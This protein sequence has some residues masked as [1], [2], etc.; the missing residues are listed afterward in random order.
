MLNPELTKKYISLNKLIDY[1]VDT[2]KEEKVPSFNSTLIDDSNC[3]ENGTFI[4]NGVLTSKLDNDLKFELPI[5]YPKYLTATCSI[6]S[7]KKND[8]VNITCKT[9]GEID[10]EN[11]MISQNTILDNNKKELLII[12]KIEA[13]KKSKCNNAKTQIIN[14]KLKNQIKISFRQ[15]NQFYPMKKKTN[16]HFIG[17]SDQLLPSEKTLKILVAI[18]F[19]GEK[20]EKEANC[21]L[22]TFSRLNALNPNYGQANFICE[23]EHNE[24]DKADDLEIISSDKILGLNDDLEDSQKSPYKT[25]KMIKETLN[26]PSLGQVLNFS[27]TTDFYDIPPTFEISS[28]NF[29]KCKDKGKIKVNG[30][31]NQKIE[32][33]FDFTIPLSYPSSSIKCTAPNIDANRNVNI[34]CKIQKDFYNAEQIIIEPRIIKKKHKEVIF[35][36][37]Y[38]YNKEKQTCKNYNTIQKTIEAAKTKNNYSF[39]QANNFMPIP[40]GLFFRILIY[41]LQN[42]FPPTIPVT[43]SIRRRIS[44]LRNLEDIQEEDEISCLP[45]GNNI[46]PE[47]KGYNCNSTIK[48]K[49]ASDFEDF[50]FESDIV[51]G[52]YEENSNPILTDNNIKSGVVPEITKD[53]KIGSFDNPEIVKDKNC[54]VSGIFD[55]SGNLNNKDLAKLKPF[56]IHYSNPPDSYSV[57]NFTSYKLMECNNAEAFEDEYIVINKQT[58]ANGMLYIPAVTSEE[59][60]SCAISSS[61]SLS[62]EIP[63]GNDTEIENRYFSKKVSSGGLN[64]G[65]IAAIVIIS[66]AIL[67]GIGVLIALI[68]NGILFSD[69]P[70]ISNSNIP[71]ISSSSANII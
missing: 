69:K 60:F 63:V 15:V 32:Q 6:K 26:E 8:N 5:A 29:D 41:S 61:S 39:L 20:I 64:G 51:P 47:I 13:Q 46:S 16:F 10:N 70:E 2:N 57:C 44:N 40:S 48:A 23:V 33:K 53:Y 18:I 27:S 36:K 58:L 67:I 62:L 43:I 25:D 54:N 37:N 22:N 19:N 42:S 3:N 30:K 34:D 7:G 12:S 71:P 59:I 28:I 17:I 56:E 1:S 11:I 9:N 21:T 50:S 66:A 49:D 65:A 31:F 35:I 52:L 45:E 55:I 14:D 4:I 38:T 24:F 68:K